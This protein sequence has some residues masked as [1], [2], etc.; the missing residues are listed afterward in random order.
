M[1]M[2]HYSGLKG[3]P[4]LS[5][6]DTHTLPPLCFGSRRKA[7]R[8]CSVQTPSARCWRWRKRGRVEESEAGW[9]RTW[10]EPHKHAAG[11][12]VPTAG[13]PPAT[14]HVSRLLPVLA[15]VISPP[16]SAG[17]RGDP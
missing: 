16:P 9:R 5:P 7:L 17:Q 8:A 2:G 13:F 6:P 14:L 4:C 3:S 11:C 1:L 10:P 15:P 12:S